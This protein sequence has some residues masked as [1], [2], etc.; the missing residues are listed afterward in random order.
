MSWGLLLRSLRETWLTSWLLGA[1]LA[2]FE[3]LLARILPAFNEEMLAQWLQVAFVRQMVAAMLGVDPDGVGGLS[4]FIA[5]GWAHPV[6]LLLVWSHAIIF[7]TRVPAGEIDRGTIDVLL[8]LPVSRTRVYLS[9]TGAWLVSGVAVVALGV[10]G[11]VLGG[12]GLDA[13][14]RAAPLRLLAVG[15]NLYS[16]SLCVGGLA[17]CVS[18]LSSRRATAASIVTALVIV[19]YVLNVLGAFSE[20]VRRLGPLNLITYFRPVYMIRDGIWPWRDMLIL[21]GV[22]ATAWAAGLLVFRRRNICTV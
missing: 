6:V 15:A 2:T 4:M 3:F 1:G 18:S 20:P 16:L 7:G 9:E 5:F 14:Q 11:S 10:A 21:L 17:F 12:I 13:D 22:A 8:G 19:S